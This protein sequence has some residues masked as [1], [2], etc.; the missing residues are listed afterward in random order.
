MGQFKPAPSA[1]VVSLPAFTPEPAMHAA[2]A[3]IAR[4]WTA[5]ARNRSVSYAGTYVGLTN[6]GVPHGP[7]TDVTQPIPGGTSP[8]VVPCQPARVTG[9]IFLNANFAD[10]VVNREVYN[11]TLEDA[12]ALD[13]GSTTMLDTIF[14]ADGD[15]AADGTFAGVINPG[16]H[17]TIGNFGGV[18]GGTNAASIAG[19]THLTDFIDSIDSKEEYWIFVL[20]QCGV[21]GASSI[22]GDVA[23]DGPAQ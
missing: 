16:D 12:A 21:S 6:L 9:D 11:R 10:N 13:S 17:T 4:R 22:C 7:A 3:L 23:P 2:A 8:S 14:F 5:R 15:I 18:F 20:G 1:M 19:T